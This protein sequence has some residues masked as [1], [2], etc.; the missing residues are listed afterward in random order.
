MTSKETI[1]GW[2]FNA[3]FFIF[4]IL[5]PSLSLQ[6]KKTSSSAHFGITKISINEKQDLA[7][8]PMTLARATVNKLLCTFSKF[9]LKLEMMF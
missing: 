1:P 3:H 9:N 2:K 4:K 5:L 8:A 6:S 7:F